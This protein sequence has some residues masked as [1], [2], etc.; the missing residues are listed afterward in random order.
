MEKT[1]VLISG[2]GPV[3][4]VLAIYLGRLGVA[5][6][7]IDR[8][9]DVYP[10]PRAAHLDHETMRLLHL[11][12]GA[13]AVLGASQPLSTYEFRTADGELLM[14]FRPG[15]VLPSTGFPQSSMFHQPTLEHALRARLAGL[16]SIS[17][18][19]GHALKSYDADEEGVRAVVSGPEGEYGVE[20][21]YIVGCDGGQSLVRRIAGIALDDMGFDEPW[22]VLDVKL[23]E[24]REKLS[25]IGLQLCDPRRPVTSMPMGPGRHRWEFMLCPGETPEDVVRDDFIAALLAPF[26]DPAS[27]VVERRAVYRF[28]AVFA[29]QWRKGRVLLAGDAAHQMPPFLGQGLCS[30]TRDAANLAWK[31][32]AVLEGRAGDVLLDSYQTERDPHVRAITEMAVFM[33]K[34]VCTQNMD[35]AAARDRDMLSKPEVER[36]SAMPETLGLKSG[37]CGGDILAGSIFPEPWM[38]GDESRTRLDDAAGFVPLLVCRDVDDEATASF[39]TGGGFVASLGASLVDEGGRLA[40]LLSENEA[41]LVRPDRYV[42]GR[43]PAAALLASWQGY[44]ASGTVAERA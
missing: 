8:D 35:Q 25:T 43:G 15:E 2:L 40:S 12:G 7:A 9:I 29:R 27:V 6:V 31:L 5:A 24:G 21:K 1:D 16:P 18:R 28:H 42:F 34:I 10:M 26:V 44:L 30:G 37:I 38:A 33:G 13:D 4:A 22:L 3:G 23:P 20:A 39:R 17:A 14:G 32:A 11:A 19:L 41:I 36:F